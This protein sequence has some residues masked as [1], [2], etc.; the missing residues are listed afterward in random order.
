MKTLTS[1]LTALVLLISTTTM[2]DASALS[3]RAESPK[4]P[5]NQ[6]NF[7]VGFVALDINEHSVSVVCE[8]KGPSDGSFTQ[9]DSTKS[10]P[11]GG[12]SG[13]CQVTTNEISP[14]GT[15]EFRVVATSA[16]GVET[17]NVV[18]VSYDD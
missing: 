2:V 10:L 11:A 15:Y 16:S 3:V 6:K 18:S 7:K 13:E 17:S 14:I 5:T 12:S 4:S 9:F 1:I 8:K